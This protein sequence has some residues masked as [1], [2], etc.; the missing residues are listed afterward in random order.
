VVC[1]NRLPAVLHLGPPSGRE[2]H[3]QHAHPAMRSPDP[4]HPIKPPCTCNA[5]E[6]TPAPSSSCFEAVLW[7]ATLAADRTDAS[8]C[9][10]A[11]AACHSAG[12]RSG[13]RPA[14]A[15]RC[16]QSQSR[17]SSCMCV[18]VIVIVI[19]CVFVCV[20]VSFGEQHISMGSACRYTDA[21]AGTAIQEVQFRKYLHGLHAGTAQIHG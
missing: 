16:C 9:A 5:A 17:A 11:A 21:G 12:D 3:T 19:V 4:P 10:A 6:H 15:R 20:C 1:K 2:A 7:A 8:A 13:G 14:A 18:I